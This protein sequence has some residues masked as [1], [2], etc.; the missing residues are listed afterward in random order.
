IET[1]RR[2]GV[3]IGVID[4]RGLGTGFPSPDG[5][6]DGGPTLILLDAEAGG[7]SYVATAT[8]GRVSMSN[9]LTTPLR[10]AAVEASAY[11]LLGF[12]PSP[13]EPGERKLKVRVLREGLRVRAPDRYIAGEPATIKKP[14]PP[15]DQALGLVSDATDIPLRVS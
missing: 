13:G 10:E 7:S 14:V 15:A 8:G 4:P 2:I 5:M 11:Y 3:S 9:D 1:A 12:Q 6:D